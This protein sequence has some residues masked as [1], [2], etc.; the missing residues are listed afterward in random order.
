MSDIDI[1]VSDNFDP[2]PGV[3]YEDETPEAQPAANEPETTEP[4]RVE[5]E[6]TENPADAAEPERVERS[7]PRP[8]ASLLEKKHELETQLEQER[9]ARAQLEDRISQLSSQAPTVRTDDDI[10]SLAAEYGLDETLLSRL[11]ATARKGISP[12]LPPEVRDLIAERETERQQQSE[13]AEF[14]NRLD[15]LARTLPSEQFTDP[16]VRQKL[17]E[18]AYSTDQAP[19][20]EPYFKKELSELYFAYIRPEIEP[21]RVSAESSQVSSKVTEIVDFEAI[22]DKDDPSDIERMDSETF[23]K[24]NA[25]VKEHRESRTPLKRN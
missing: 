4:A 20:G 13:I 17:M 24:F 1:P 3:E 14:N 8:I 15:S 22:Y 19:D 5:P 7:K 23:A 16:Q 12:E 21:G 2:V 25:W 11:V 9:Q 10:E 18:L 6:T